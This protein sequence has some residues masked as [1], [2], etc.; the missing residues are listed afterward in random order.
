MIVPTEDNS[1]SRDTDTNA[2]INTNVTAYM[3]YKQQRDGGKTVAQLTQDINEL[4]SEFG[5]IKH[6]LTELLRNVKTNS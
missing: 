3:L 5:E 4:K 1:F 2:V 6:L